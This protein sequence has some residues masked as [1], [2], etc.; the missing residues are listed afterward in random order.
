M[1]SARGAHAASR[2]GKKY[3]KKKIAVVAK[4]EIVA[5]PSMK[6]PT[7]GLFPFG[8]VMT[9]DPSYELIDSPLASDDE[10]YEKRGCYD[11]EDEQQFDLHVSL[12]RFR[13][14][15][16]A[17]HRS[18]RK[19]KPDADRQ[20]RSRPKNA[21]RPRD[22]GGKFRAKLCVQDGECAFLQTAA[23][24]RGDEPLVIFE[25]VAGA[26]VDRKCPKQEYGAEDTKPVEDAP[27][28]IAEGQ[29]G[30]EILCLQDICKDQKACAGAQDADAACPEDVSKPD[31]PDP[32]RFEA[33][34]GVSDASVPILRDHPRPVS[35][36]IDVNRTKIAR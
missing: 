31:A 27:G 26:V 2:S 18:V 29:V 3:A 19:P 33:S 1:S 4:S 7:F 8:T 32:D 16:G 20:E 35:I 5:N 34:D 22:Q 13:K 25:N 11:V 15:Q 9:F 24:G 28:E 10:H 23:R 36:P 30:K 12:A 21:R 6:G 14:R 17:I